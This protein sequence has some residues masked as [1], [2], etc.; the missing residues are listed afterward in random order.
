[1][2]RLPTLGCCILADERLFTTE[3]G[4]E[5]ARKEA[6]LEAVDE[7]SISERLA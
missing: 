4:T 3:L 7:A 6:L 5:G 2:Q 1:M